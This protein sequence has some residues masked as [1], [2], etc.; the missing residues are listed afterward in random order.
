M[1]RYGATRAL[2][3]TMQPFGVC[4]VVSAYLDK[5]S[6]P[7]AAIICHDTLLAANEQ[8]LFMY[9]SI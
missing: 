8:S 3:L 4:T 5:S 7:A 9:S 1:Q 2:L 6:V